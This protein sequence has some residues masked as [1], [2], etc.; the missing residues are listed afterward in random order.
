[1]KRNLLTVLLVT[2]FAFAFILNPLAH[3]ELKEGMSQG[4]FAIWLVKAVGAMYKLPPGANAQDAV[5]FLTNLGLVP[6]GDWQVDGIV[7]KQFLISFLNLSQEEADALLK[8]PEGFDKL[9][10]KVRELLQSRF[11]DA[12]QGVFRVQ[13][14]SGSVP[15]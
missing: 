2:L 13:S 12:R 6:D 9:L 11:D 5:D 8:D 7:D 3:A 15:A 10:A 14:A 4:E 1:M